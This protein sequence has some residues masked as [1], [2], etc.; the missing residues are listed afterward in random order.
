MNM[1]PVMRIEVLSAV[2]DGKSRTLLPLPLPPSIL[3]Y[4]HLLAPCN[5]TRRSCLT[6]SNQPRKINSSATDQHFDNAE[7]QIQ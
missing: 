6:F 2:V 3:L 1:M 7:D 5:L 4:V